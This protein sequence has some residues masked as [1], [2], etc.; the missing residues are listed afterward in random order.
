MSKAAA[1]PGDHAD[2]AGEPP[3]PDRSEAFPSVERM[4]HYRLSRRTVQRALRSLE[5][6]GLIREGN[7]RVRDA[8]V[9]RADQ[10]PQVY[11]LVLSAGLS[12]ASGTGRQDGAPLT[13]TGRQHDARTAL[14]PSGKPSRAERVLHRALGGAAGVRSVRRRRHHPVSARVV[15]P[16]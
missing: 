9:E 16:D 1:A 11:D 10:R 4:T 2:R 15:S 14:R 6:L 7:T 13:S 3:R 5:E 12:A 8:R